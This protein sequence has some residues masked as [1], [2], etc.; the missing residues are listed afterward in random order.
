M[1][2]KLLEKSETQADYGA[3]HGVEYEYVYECPCGKNK[4][5][6]YHDAVPGFRSHDIYVDCAECASKWD[7]KKGGYAEERRKEE[8]QSSL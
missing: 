7:V 1:K 8:I 4:V 5:R 6:E 3:G 2:L